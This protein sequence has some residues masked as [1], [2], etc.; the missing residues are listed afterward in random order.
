MN[1]AIL[2]Y[3]KSGNTKKIADHIKHIAEK[4]NHTVEIVDIIPEK[5]PHFFKAGYSAVRQ[6]T[7]PIKNEPID[8][9]SYDVVFVGCPIWAG[10]PAPFIKS[11][12]QKTTGFS[13]LKTCV[14][15]TCAGGEQPGS[16][17]VDLIKSYAKEQKASVIDNSL[18]VHM[19]GKGEIKKEIPSIK[20][21]VSSIIDKI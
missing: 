8:V 16:K 6:K 21:F 5:Q 10:K 13:N 14:F 9:S 1:I 7:L 19:S 3:S 15:I 4:K 11:M 17:A 2:F 12:I 20:D 18:I